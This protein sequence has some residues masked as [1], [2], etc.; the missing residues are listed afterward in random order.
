ML[1]YSFC[2]FRYVLYLKCLFVGLLD[3]LGLLCLVVVYCLRGFVFVMVAGFEMLIYGLGVGACVFGVG[4]GDCFCKF[5]CLLYL[6][7]CLLCLVI[8]L[9]VLFVIVLW[10]SVGRLFGEF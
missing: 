10:F 4:W 6:L 7:D 1:L 3:T 2:Y 5:I 8:D 9:C